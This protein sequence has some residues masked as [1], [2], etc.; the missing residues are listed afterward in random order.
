MYLYNY[1]SY[2]VSLNGIWRWPATRHRSTLGPPINEPS[3]PLDSWRGILAR[4]GG[5]PSCPLPGDLRLQSFLE[6]GFRSVGDNAFTPTRAKAGKPWMVV[7]RLALPYLPCPNT[8]AGV[9]RIQNC[10]SVRFFAHRA[11]VHQVS[12]N[13][14]WRW[15]ATRHRSTLGPPIDEPSILLDLWR[16]IL[17]RGGALPP[18]HCLVTSVYS[19]FWS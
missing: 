19:R 10:R 3:I 14:I 18:V 7:V 13:G 11:Q 12:L 8:L 4:G 17:A 6:L 1:L 2:Q 15:R 16:G 5:S 9:D